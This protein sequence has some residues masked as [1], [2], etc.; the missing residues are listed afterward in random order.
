MASSASDIWSIDGVETGAEKVDGK[1]DK[2]C[3]FVIRETGG[4][5]GGGGAGEEDGVAGES[6]PNTP[7]GRKSK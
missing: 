5:A 4:G 6:M 2:R 7:N 1:T 3:E